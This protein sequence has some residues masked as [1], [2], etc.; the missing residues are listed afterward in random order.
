MTTASD[1]P[2]IKK[3]KAQNGNNSDKPSKKASDSSTTTDDEFKPYTLPQ[4][5][6]KI[7][8]LE[9]KVPTVPTNGLD[10]T[11]RNAVRSWAAQMQAIVEEFNLLLCC[12]SSATYRWGTDRSGAADQNLGLL[13]SE[14]GNAQDQISTSITPRLSNV[15]AP[16]VDLVTKES[17]TT[18]DEKGVMTKV[19]HFAQED[20]DPA[21]IALCSEILSR[22]APMLSHVLLT[23]FHKV[24][25]CIDDYLKATKKDGEG[26]RNAFAY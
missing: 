24:G 18:T 23:N 19:N 8:S 11:D 2:I 7:K 15:L 6:S 26:Q 20:N 25:R 14:L 16:V 17:V 5:R 4:I 21:F 22:N 9:I 10:S 1:E 13:S 3:R 12:V